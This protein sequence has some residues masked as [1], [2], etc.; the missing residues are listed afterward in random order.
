MIILEEIEQEK[1][2]NLPITKKQEKKLN[3]VSKKLNK[4]HNDFIAFK[5]TLLIITSKKRGNPKCRAL[6]KTYLDGLDMYTIALST[7]RLLQFETFPDGERFLLS[8]V[9]GNPITQY[10]FKKVLSVYI[11]FPLTV[12][13]INGTVGILDTNS[14][15]FNPS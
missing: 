5:D 8:D 2:K 6:E 7:N 14:G 1:A 11:E 15:Q 10:I 12:M 4:A 3:K 13:D 9:E